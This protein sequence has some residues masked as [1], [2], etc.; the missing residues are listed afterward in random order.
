MKRGIENTYLKQVH[1][2]TLKMYQKR[3]AY[4]F[5]FDH[6]NLLSKPPNYYYAESFRKHS[7]LVYGTEAF[8]IIPLSSCL[9]QNLSPRIR[10]LTHNGF[11][12]TR[13]AARKRCDT[14]KLNPLKVFSTARPYL[15]NEDVSDMR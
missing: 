4:F 5:V 6:N 11:G 1:V 14:L 7:V 10:P 12:H 3:F 2:F 8:R 15:I 9:V 13:C